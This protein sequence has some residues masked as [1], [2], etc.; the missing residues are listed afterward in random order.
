MPPTLLS[1]FLAAGCGSAGGDAALHVATRF[2]DAVAAH[3]GARACRYLAP[4]TR[5]ELE[6]S[7]GEPCARAVLAEDFPSVRGEG[8]V[9]RFGNQAAVKLSEDTVFLAEFNVG[10]RV[11]AAVCT[12]RGALPHDCQVKGV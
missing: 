9:R 12:P 8:E 10:W 2:Y 6:S 11:V 1:G 4:Q 7:A 5:H 3:D